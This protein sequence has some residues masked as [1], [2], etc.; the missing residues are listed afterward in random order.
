M[1]IQDAPIASP[2]APKSNDYQQMVTQISDAKAQQQVVENILREYG[3]LGDVLERRA[4]SDGDMVCTTWLND[5]GDVETKLTFGELHRK[6]GQVA[7]TLQ[8]NGVEPGDKVVLLYPPGV[9]FDLAFWGCALAGVVSVPVYPPNPSNLKKD[10][11]KLAHVVADAGVKVALSVK[12][13][14]LV[15][16]MGA[17][18]PGVRWP[19]IKWIDTDSLKNDWEYEPRSGTS[20][21]DLSYFQYTSGSTSDPKGVVI[22]QRNI[23]AQLYQYKSTVVEQMQRRNDATAYDEFPFST[24]VSWLPQY[25]DFGLVVRLM[26][27]YARF[28]LIGACARI[29]QLI[30]LTK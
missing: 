19:N 2:A 6:A 26:S 3:S 20:L 12:K 1:L 10:V 5:K 21:E 14:H 8:A 7:A 27:V 24:A 29:Q 15:A 11:P 30:V 22:T 4:A 9:D 18:S 23:L 16:K 13:L 28:E 25:H 17:L